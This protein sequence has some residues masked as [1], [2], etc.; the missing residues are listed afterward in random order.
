VI[1]FRSIVVRS[2]LGAILVVA[3]GGTS[4]EVFKCAGERGRPVYQ[5]T[6]CPPGRELRDFQLNP[7][8]IT[9]LPAPEITGPAAGRTSGGAARPRNGGRDPKPAKPTATESNAAERKHVR[10]G[11]SEAEVIAR[12]GQPDVTSAGKNRKGARWTY[13][14]APGDPE[15]ITSLTFGNGVVTDVERKIF[16]K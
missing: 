6:P 9:V 16:R 14:P 5:D 10:T 11:M 13:L 8:E 7:P 2:V 12:L 3:A 4:A 15:T 1:V